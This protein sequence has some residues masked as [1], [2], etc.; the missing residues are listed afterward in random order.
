MGIDLAATRDLAALV[1]LIEKDDKLYVKSE[2]FLPQNDKS[3]VRM[4]GLDLTD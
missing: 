3:I 4:N 1:V 2:H